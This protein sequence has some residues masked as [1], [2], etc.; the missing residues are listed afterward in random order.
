M[1]STCHSLIHAGLLR[2]EGDPQGGLKWTPKCE[3]SD[4]SLS[5]ELARATTVAEV[6]V[7]PLFDGGSGNSTAVE[8]ENSTAVENENST[9]VENSPLHENSPAVE[10]SQADTDD[11]LTEALIGAGCT[12]KDARRR[13]AVARAR[14]AAQGEAATEE[15]ILREALRASR[16]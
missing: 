11:L 2:V 9:A 12:E 13:L 15:N 14:L 10:F 16:R 1:C 6:H 7:K 3:D 4:F 8:N 5:E